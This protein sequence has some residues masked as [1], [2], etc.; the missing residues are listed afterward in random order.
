L[1]IY[2]S[3]VRVVGSVSAVAL[4]VSTV[5]MPPAVAALKIGAGPAGGGRVATCSSRWPASPLAMARITPRRN[6]TI[7]HE[8]NPPGPNYRE[9]FFGRRFKISLEGS[10]R[11]KKWI[12]LISQSSRPVTTEFQNFAFSPA[13]VSAGPPL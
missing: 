9:R 2:L 5:V 4:A 3:L 12:G 13:E 7:S 8:P 10:N 1:A 11:F 6:G